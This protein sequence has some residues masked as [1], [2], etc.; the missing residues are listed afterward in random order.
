MYCDL[1]GKHSAEEDTLYIAILHDIGHGPF[2]PYGTQYMSRM[3]IM[4]KY[5]C[6]SCTNSIKFNGQLNLAIQVFEG[7]YK[8]NLCCSIIK[9][10]GYGPNGLFKNVIVLP[11]V[12]EGNVNSERL[13]K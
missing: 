3:C 4:N 5:P 7:D 8:E 10:V 9:S 1:K 6:C 13:I 12:A 2:S 11:G